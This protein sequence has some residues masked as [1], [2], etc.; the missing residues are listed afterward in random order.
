MAV[1]FPTFSNTIKRFQGKAADEKGRNV[2]IHSSSLY[3]L[4]LESVPGGLEIIKKSVL[5][6]RGNKR[7]QTA[8]L[9]Q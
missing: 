2:P 8:V 7:V 4:R 1:Y 9:W 5:T 6:I 3:A